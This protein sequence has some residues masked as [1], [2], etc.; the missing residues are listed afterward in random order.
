MSKLA[1]TI[2]LSLAVAAGAGVVLFLFDPAQ[3]AIYPVC[4]FHN[5][6][7]WHCPGCGSLRALHHLAHGE[8]TAGFRHNPLLV[9]SL[10]LVA[11]LAGRQLF[12]ARSN[13]TPLPSSIR[14]FGPWVALGVIV[15]FGILRNLPYPAFA[16]M[17]P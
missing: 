9:V 14:S 4:H 2:C 13:R 17:S 16:W 15:L 1:W 5:L 8:L 6:T 3:T 7:G 12:G 11:W 10:P